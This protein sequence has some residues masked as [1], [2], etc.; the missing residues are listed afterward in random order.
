M[1]I[2]PDAMRRFFTYIV[3]AIFLAYYPAI[4][5][6]DLPD[7]FNMPAFVPFL[8]PFVGLGLLL[9]ALAFWRFG[10]KYYQS[11]GS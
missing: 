5:I 1:H 10:M 4:Y 11:T 2:F 6:L 3:P 8:A 7:P 9:A